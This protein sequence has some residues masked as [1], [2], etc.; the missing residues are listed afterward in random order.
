LY[1]NFQN[2]GSLGVAV[3][4]FDGLD[5]T[6]ATAFISSVSYA[7]DI[8]IQGTFPSDRQLYLSFNPADIK[9]ES[10]EG[11]SFVSFTQ[12][13]SNQTCGAPDEYTNQITETIHF[14]TSSLEGDL[15][16]SS[17]STPVVRNLARLSG[18]EPSTYAPCFAGEVTKAAI[19]N[20]GVQVYDEDGF[21]V[22]GY[23]LTNGLYT[24]YELEVGASGFNQSV[25][26]VP[27]GSVSFP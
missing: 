20:P 8:N 4:L 23:V 18:L 13:V 19:L 26:I 11:E 6:T 1:G 22:T 24:S 21:L 3:K 10:S 15:S 27:A 5:I 25:L 16:Q 7:P 14:E 12:N 9:F 17:Q 2:G